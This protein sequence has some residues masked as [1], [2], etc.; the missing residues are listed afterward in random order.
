MFDVE[1]ELGRPPAQTRLLCLPPLLTPTITALVLLSIRMLTEAGLEGGAIRGTDMPE[2][3]L[4]GR[5]MP[6]IRQR[7][8]SISPRASCIFLVCVGGED[9]FLSSPRR[10]RT[11]STHTLLPRTTP[12]TR[13]TCCQQLLCH[14]SPP[15]PPHHH[16]QLLLLATPRRTRCASRCQHSYFVLVKQVN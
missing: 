5:R 14:L 16:H 10:L 2:V 13:T 1:V 11:R 3:R 8:P 15:P 6:S 7:M 12:S 9:L 4:R